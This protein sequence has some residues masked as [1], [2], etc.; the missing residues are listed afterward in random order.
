MLDTL[1]PEECI[2]LTKVTITP[3]GNAYTIALYVMKSLVDENPKL[4]WEK[5]FIDPTIVLG[6][7][8][9]SDLRTGWERVPREMMEFYDVKSQI[10]S[11]YP[12]AVKAGLCGYSKLL[13]VRL[14]ENVVPD[15]FLTTIKWTC[16]K[17]AQTV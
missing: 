13:A 6:C 15:N 11:V 1:I 9:D 14:A 7:I 3:T 10:L 12:L 4:T 2:P 8:E 5:E 17:N 16:K